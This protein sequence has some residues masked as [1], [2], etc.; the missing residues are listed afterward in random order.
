MLGK[1]KANKLVKRLKTCS[2]SVITA[3][4]IVEK[5]NET[6]VREADRLGLV[7]ITSK[8]YK[9][10][11]ATIDNCLA[12]IANSEGVHIDT[13]VSSK[14]SSR[15]TAENSLISSM[16]LVILVACTH[17]IVVEKTRSRNSKNIESDN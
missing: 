11:R 2:G 10:C 12:E 3:D 13:S 9:P 4:D 6:R 7:P 15:Y 17:F 8:H 5:I 14:T 16:A 1:P